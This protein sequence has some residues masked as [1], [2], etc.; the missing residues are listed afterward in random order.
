M[1][2]KTLANLMTAVLERAKLKVEDRKSIKA[3]L[4]KSDVASIEIED[5]DYD[6][7]M[8]NLHSIETASNLLK[9]KFRAEILDGVD[10]SI[11][12]ILG[13]GLG[14]SDLETIKSEKQT[15]SKLRKAFEAQ[16]KALETKLKVAKKDGD[17]NEEEKLRK[18]IDRITG[19]FKTAKD[20]LE[21]QIEELKANHQ[22][23]LFDLSLTQKITS[24]EDIADDFKSLRHFAQNF[25]ADLDEFLQKNK[26]AVSFVDGKPKLLN[27]DTKTDFLKK[28]LTHGDIDWVISSVIKEYQYEKKSETPPR[29]DVT[30]EKFQVGSPEYIRQQTIAANQALNS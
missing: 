1:A 23:E 16:K 4:D 29:G 30:I 24:R 20:T 7:V 15:A 14:D 17:S 10:S 25:K 19:E 8:G 11:L 27:S 3:I 18:E 2:K 12:E 26:I 28:D 9:P 5:E 22:S 13:E 6:E 21:N